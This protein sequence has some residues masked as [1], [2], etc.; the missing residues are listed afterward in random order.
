MAVPSDLNLTLSTTLETGDI[1][2][3]LETIDRDAIRSI[4]DENVGDVLYIPRGYIHNASC[5]SDQGSIHLTLTVQSTT[6]SWNNFLLHSLVQS[7]H[8]LRATP[9]VVV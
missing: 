5:D 6:F 4:N 7:T 1:R 3:C 2:F 9:A 8:H